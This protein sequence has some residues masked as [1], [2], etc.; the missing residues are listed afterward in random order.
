MTIFKNFINY[1]IW[2]YHQ[3][4]EKEFDRR[5]GIDT[6]E[7][8]EPGFSGAFP[9]SEK[10]AVEYEPIHLHVLKDMFQYIDSD[11]TDTTYID[12]GSGKGRSLF[13]ASELSFNKIIGVEFS[14]ELHEIA[15][16]NIIRFRQN[17]NNET[18]I[19][20][21]EMD[22][23]QFDFPKSNLVI[24]LYN[25]FFG[26]VMKKVLEKME[27]FIKNENYTIKILYRNPKCASM[28]KA[29]DYFIQ[30]VSKDTYHIYESMKP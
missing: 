11:L 4:K 27:Q 8:I 1:I 13:M 6:Q 2:R 16:N 12:L 17:T 3:W 28:F 30:A 29:S 25:P 9:D 20:V 15:S 14:K 10:F 7:P 23:T 21:Y 26:K 22:V 19:S 18:D 24:F 5:Y